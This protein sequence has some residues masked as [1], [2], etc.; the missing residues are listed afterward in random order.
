MAE[1]KNPLHGSGTMTT[2]EI[3]EHSSKKFYPNRD[4]KQIYMW[5][6]QA[7]ASNEYRML[8]EH[9]TLFLFKKNG[10]VAEHCYMF[11]ADDAKTIVKAFERGAKIFKLSGFNKIETD[12]L[13]P[14]VIRLARY[15]RL[16]V[17]SEVRDGVHHV[18]V[19]L[20]NV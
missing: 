13:D 8:R 6:H 16:P 7:I 4:W 12:V 19:D 9:N 14:N 3:V 17:K 20:T 18:E 15:A 5:L 10:N 2:Q 11:S 1:N